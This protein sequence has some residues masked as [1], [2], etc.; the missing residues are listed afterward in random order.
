MKDFKNDPE[1]MRSLSPMVEGRSNKSHL[2]NIRQKDAF[3]G[4]MPSY[5]FSPKNNL[6]N[7]R[8]N[9]GMSLERSNLDQG[10]FIN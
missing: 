1:F 5:N 10:N 6:A 2:A 4:L 8:L 7:M 9:N 3:S